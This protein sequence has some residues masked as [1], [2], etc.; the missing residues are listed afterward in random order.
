MNP[1]IFGISPQRHGDTE[2]DPFGSHIQIKIQ[3]GRPK[4]HPYINQIDLRVSVP[5]W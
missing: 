4:G 3:T 1:G 5:L 2:V